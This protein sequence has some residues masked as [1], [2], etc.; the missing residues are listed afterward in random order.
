MVA[1]VLYIVYNENST[2]TGLHA[3][4]QALKIHETFPSLE[5]LIVIAAHVW[6]CE[7]RQE[8]A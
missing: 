8:L 2:L 5:W 6:P 7:L 3:D 4:G 1:N